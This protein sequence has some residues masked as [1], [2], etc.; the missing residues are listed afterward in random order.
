MN[1]SLLTALVI[2]AVVIALGVYFFS[3]KSAAEPI[4]ETKNSETDSLNTFS[5]NGDVAYEVDSDASILSYSASRI[6]GNTHTGTVAISEGFLSF[7]DGNFENGSFTVDMTT[8]TDDSENEMYLTHVA[9]DDFFNVEEFPTSTFNITSITPEND[10]TFT[11][12]GD[13]TIRDVTNAVSFPAMFSESGDG[14]VTALA[15]FQIDRTEWGVNF[16]SGSIFQQ[17]GDKAIRD[18][19]LYDLNLVLKQ[20]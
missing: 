6:A 10:G 14:Q 7:L 9:S 17:L 15:A 3:P 18:E 5:F 19:I 13:L 8:I 16:D 12:S 4:E 2:G 1:K 20:I 11:V